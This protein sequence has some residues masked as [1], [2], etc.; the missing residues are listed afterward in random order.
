MTKDT[1]YFSHDYNARSDQKIS[2]LLAKHGMLGYG[3]YWAIIENLYNNNNT[4]EIDYDCLSYDL[5]SDSEIIKS[6]INDF[7]L[8]EFYE[9]TF[10]SISV[11]RRLNERTKKTKKAEDSA[12]ARWSKDNKDEERKNAVQ[13]LLYAIKIYDESESFIKVGITTESVSR[14]YSGKLNY[15]QYEMI[16]SCE[17]TVEKCL[18]YEQTI[19]NRFKNYTPK[20]QFAGYLECLEI[21]QYDELINFVMQDKMFRNANI[22]FRNAIKE[23][24]G[25]E[26]KENK[27]KDS[28]VHKF[29]PPSINELKSFIEQQKYSVN[30]EYFMNFYDSKGWMIGKN[31]MKDWQ[32]AVRTWNSKNKA[33]QA[34][35]KDDR[36]ISIDYDFDNPDNNFANWKA[37]ENNLHLD[38]T[39]MAIKILKGENAGKYVD[40]ETVNKSRRLTNLFNCYASMQPEGLSYL[41]REKY[42]MR[43]I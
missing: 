28:G 17:N 41:S 6:V 1:F 4:L 14:R 18:E 20:K 15:Y 9:N 5:R 36:F 12:N 30:A 13:C 31:K 23:R 10:G 22:I 37:V 19:K 40:F 35:S 34:A 16:F 43:K 32:A 26:K 33:E 21:S 29:T 25:K 7:G 8:F 39:I 42:G 11:E 24:K 2:K 3:L 38:Y 27:D